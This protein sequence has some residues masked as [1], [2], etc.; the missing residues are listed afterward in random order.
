M[1]EASYRRITTPRGM[2]RGGED[3]A[4]YGIDLADLVGSAATPSLSASLPGRIR[5]E[6]EKDERIAAVS[7]TLLETRLGPSV[8]YAITIR[9]DTEEGP[10]T[11]QVEAS[12]VTVELLGITEAA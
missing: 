7:V 9:A 1:A 5:A 6:I 3:E 4:N 2:L 10:F 11:L 8:S 12:A